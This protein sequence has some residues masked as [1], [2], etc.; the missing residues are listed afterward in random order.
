MPQL[1]RH[2]FAAGL[3]VICAATPGVSLAQSAWRPEK[4][5]EIIL[6]TSAGGLNDQMARLVQRI[7]QDRKLV[8]T[9][10]LVMNKSGGNQTLAAVYLRQHPGDPHYLLYS[11]SSIFTGQITGLIQQHYSD[12]SPIALMMVE[13]TAITVAADS[14]IRNMRDLIERLAANPES[15][16]F[17]M[18]TRGGTNHL[19]LA[20]AVKSVGIDPR[21]LK[22]VVFKTNVESMTALVG[23]HLHVVTTSATAALPW[24][25]K[26]QA[27]MLAVLAPQRQ[28]GPL[29]NVPTLRE[30]GFDVAGVTNWRGMFGAR[31]LTAAQIEFWEDAMAKVVAT[32]EW[33][34]PLEQNH[35]AHTFLRGRDFVKFLES[36]YQA[37]RAALTDLGFAK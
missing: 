10:V 33:Q 18:A 25:Q 14:P 6:P 1:L 30:Q 20:Q 11:T 3:A 34:K 27:R 26:G 36:E 2:V 32:E 24:V 29:A 8:T 16:A 37:S 5:V 13:R 22:T 4:P 19:G 12:L 15:L 23:G 35:L 21:R 7:L 17:G 31:G 28:S 9:P